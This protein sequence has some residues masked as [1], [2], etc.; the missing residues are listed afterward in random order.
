MIA[1]YTASKGGVGQVTKVMST[2]WAGH[3]IKVNCICPGYMVTDLTKDIATK[4]PAQYANINARLPIGRWGTSDDL[5]GAV[6]FLSSDASDYISG[7][8]LVIDGGYT[9]K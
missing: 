3:G 7:T 8:A 2:E 5:K 4:N 1:G 6:V 9:V